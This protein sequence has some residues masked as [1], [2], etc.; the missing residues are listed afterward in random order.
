MRSPMNHMSASAKCSM[1]ISSPSSPSL[2]PVRR[3]ISSISL[4]KWKLRLPESVMWEGDRDPPSVLSGAGGAAH[5]PRWLILA[6]TPCCPFYC[7]TP[8]PLRFSAAM[9][10]NSPSFAR[11]LPSFRTESQASQESPQ[12]WAN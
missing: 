3:G 5:C 2:I 9:V 10:T 1:F 4:P 6:L 7:P 11:D 12:F 8:T